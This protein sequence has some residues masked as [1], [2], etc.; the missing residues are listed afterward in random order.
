MPWGLAS[1]SDILSPTQ[2]LQ[3]QLNQ[4]LGAQAFV[5]GGGAVETGEEA[6]GPLSTARR[7]GAGGGG[8]LCPLQSVIHQPAQRPRRNV[9]KRSTVLVLRHS[10]SR[11]QPLDNKM[12][13][14][15]S[16]YRQI[17]I[18]RTEGGLGCVTSNKADCS[19]EILWRHNS[20]AYGVAKFLLENLELLRTGGLKN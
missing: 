15:S 10:Y 1:V 14:S 4:T 11:Q 18:S 20:K 8:V 6:E 5:A 19:S 16:H 9:L 17:Q 2:A 7:G 12:S 3:S 13:D